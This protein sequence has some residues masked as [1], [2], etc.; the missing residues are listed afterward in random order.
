LASDH[1]LDCLKSNDL[2]EFLNSSH[3]CIQHLLV[4]MFGV[5]SDVSCAHSRIFSRSSL[6]SPTRSCWGSMTLVRGRWFVVRRRKQLAQEGL[7]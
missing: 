2:L 3:F 4:Y 7:D 1:L 6:A 5:T